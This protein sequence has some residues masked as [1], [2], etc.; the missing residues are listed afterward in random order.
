MTGANYADLL[1]ALR[2]MSISILIGWAVLGVTLALMSVVEMTKPARPPSSKHAWFNIRYSM[3]MQLLLAALQPVMVGVPLILPRALGA[4][5]ITF[6]DGVLAGASGS[7]WCCWLPT[8]WS[9][10]SI[11]H[12]TISQC[13]GKCMS[14]ITVPSISMSQ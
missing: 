7:W 11:G 9:I 14:C 2:E 8:C 6:A 3:A 1:C 10:F 13:Y 12:S 5:W 4:G